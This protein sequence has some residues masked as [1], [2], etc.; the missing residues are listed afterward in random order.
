M[1][2][3]V[4]AYGDDVHPHLIVR[5]RNAAGTQSY[6]I[7]AV[8]VD[9][10]DEAHRLYGARS[11]TLVLIRPDG[12]IAFRGEATTDMLFTYLDDV[13][14]PKGHPVGATSRI[15][16]DEQSTE[17]SVPE[18]SDPSGLVGA[19]VGVE[20]Y[21]YTLAAAERELGDSSKMQ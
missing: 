4:D 10:L 9:V 12:Y 3:V 17:V 18:L 15:S 2:R 13:F 21:S 8:Y 14:S 1:E 5:P 6:P 11:G 7:S 19:G 20:Q 16:M